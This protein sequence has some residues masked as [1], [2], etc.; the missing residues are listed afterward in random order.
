MR[1]SSV[2]VLLGL[3]L[4]ACSGGGGGGGGNLVAGNYELDLRSVRVDLPGVVTTFFQ[5]AGETSRV[6]VTDLTVDDFTVLENGVPRTQLESS[7]QLLKTPRQIRNY[8]ALLLDRSGS[9]VLTAAGRRAQVEA[10]LAFANSVTDTSTQLGVFL[11]DGST[12]VTTQQTF[13]NDIAAITAAIEAIEGLAPNSAATRLYNG[14]VQTAAKLV[15]AKQAAQLEGI[16]LATTSLLTFTDGRD[17]VDSS[18]DAER[19]AQAV[20]A[21]ATLDSSFTIGLGSEFD[22]AAL[23]AIGFSGSDFA[24]GLVNLV[25]SFSAIAGL[26]TATANSF[27]ALAYCSPL[28][29]SSDTNTLDVV[30]NRTGGRI[31]NLTFSSIGFGPGCAFL[32]EASLASNPPRSVEGYFVAFAERSDSGVMVVGSRPEPAGG[33]EQ[34]IVARLREDRQFEPS[35][36]VDGVLAIPR[37]A[38]G[39]GRATAIVEVAEDTFVLLEAANDG[40]GVVRPELILIEGGQAGAR[41]VVNVD[42]TFGS[43]PTDLFYDAAASRLLVCSTGNNLF[44]G[45]LEQRITAVQLAAGSFAIDATY[46]VGGAVAVSWPTADTL[47]ASSVFANDAGRVVACYGDWVTRRVAATRFDAAGQ[48]DPS[49][50]AVP[51][52]LPAAFASLNLQLTDAASS[53]AGT[54]ISGYVT[55]ATSVPGFGDEGFVLR[56]AAN[57]SIDPTFAGSQSSPLYETGWVS[58]PPALRTADLNAFSG[59]FDFLGVSYDPTSNSVFLS[60]SRRNT[61][62]DSDATFLNVAESGTLRIAYN[63]TGFVIRDGSLGSESKELASACGLL[64]DGSTIGV[65]RAI[66]AGSA[67]DAAPVVWLGPTLV[68]Q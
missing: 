32:D 11:F 48:I 66:P 53:P 61:R 41:F 5:V 30:E 37:N 16:P 25:D 7:L 17:T 49:F 63:I 59:P 51:T 24:A 36:G 47:Q 68:G 2:F 1:A 26:T 9:I 64:S 28:G 54:L 62:G 56:I 52:G 19:Q 22:P 21:V 15:E 33:A 58:V 20:S 14:V 38:A 42:P 3:I 55:A 4:C 60:G 39:A 8:V 29:N 65:G 50:S 6:P 12:D 13:T 34:S 57:G 27:Y 67:T 23:Q 44:A 40:A 46:G 43:M 10:A 31:T 45:A 18:T 35:F